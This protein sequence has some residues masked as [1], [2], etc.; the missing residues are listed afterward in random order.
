M[1]NEELKSLETARKALQCIDVQE[2]VAIEW[3]LNWAIE[4]LDM[5]KKRVFFLRALKG[6]AT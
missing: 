1:T 6:E 2:D 5:V 3:G 4:V